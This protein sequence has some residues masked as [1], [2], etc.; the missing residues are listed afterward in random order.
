MIWLQ[1]TI[2]MSR[3]LLYDRETGKE[4]SAVHGIILFKN[5]SEFHKKEEE[6]KERLQKA[7]QEADAESKAKTDFMNRIS[8]DIRTPIN[9]IMGMLEILRKNEHNPEKMEEC[10]DKIQVSADHLLA[11]V[12]DVLDMNKLET[13][14]IQEE[15]EPFD[16]EVLMREVAVLMNP[17]L[18]QNQITH[19]VHR[20][21]IQHTALKGSPLQLRQIMLNLFSNAVKY[22]KPQGSVDTDVEE[23]S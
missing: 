11:L 4:R 2:L 3:E 18:E 7:V 5:T 1:K 22:N 9:G 12:N 14:Q 16:L 10:M 19:R 13:N 15:N 6:E 21:N 17:L 8:H 20:K 23:L